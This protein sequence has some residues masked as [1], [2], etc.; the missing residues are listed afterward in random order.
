MNRVVDCNSYGLKFRDSVV[1]IYAYSRQLIRLSA[2]DVLN[3]SV[4]GRHTAETLEGADPET[5]DSYRD[6]TIVGCS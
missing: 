2:T 5:R 1:R 4:Q 3:G 6:Q